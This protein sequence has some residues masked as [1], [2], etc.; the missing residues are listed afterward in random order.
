VRFMSQKTCFYLSCIQLIVISTPLVAKIHEPILGLSKVLVRSK[1]FVSTPFK[2][3]M[4]GG[5]ADD[6]EG[7]S[8]HHHNL[9]HKHH[10]HDDDDDDDDDNA[11]L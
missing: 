4:N 10:D 7:H 1:V 6:D 9:P 3:R 5:C 2:T 8:N 11:S